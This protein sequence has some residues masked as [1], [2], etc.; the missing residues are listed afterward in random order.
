MNRLQ[1]KTAVVTGGANK[2]GRQAAEL[3]LKEGANVVIVDLFR[4]S[5][6]EAAGAIEQFGPIIAV[7]AD[8]SQEEDVQNYV[9]KTVRQFG[10]ID[11]FFHNASIEGKKAPLAEQTAEDF[12]KVLSV[13]TRSVFLGLKYVIPVMRKQLS[14]NIVTLSSAA[15]FIGSP[16]SAPYAAS[17]HA[18]AGLVKTAALETAAAGIHVNL[19]FASPSTGNAKIMSF[20]EEGVNSLHSIEGMEAAAK[21]TPAGRFGKSEEIAKLVLGLALNDS[22]SIIE[23][24]YSGDE[25]MTAH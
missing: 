23:S 13:N 16:D 19:I 17:E 1:G 5:L 22:S 11:V 2:I 21:S 15:G 20:L 4:D 14:G 8:V 9:K 12:D 10:G 18:V 3:F 6:E 7:Q 24:P 25:S